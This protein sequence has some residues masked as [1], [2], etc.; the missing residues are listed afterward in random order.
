[1]PALLSIK[2]SKE[3]PGK[4]PLNLSREIE[5]ENWETTENILAL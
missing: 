5:E 1:M 2:W 4:K 3:N